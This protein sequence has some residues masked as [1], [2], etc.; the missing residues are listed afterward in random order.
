MIKANMRWGILIF[1]TIFSTLLTNYCRWI[2]RL[3]AF[4]LS[5]MPLPLCFI[6]LNIRCILCLF[7]ILGSCL[8]VGVLWINQENFSTYNKNKGSPCLNGQMFNNYW[9]AVYN[10]FRINEACC[11]TLTNGLMTIAWV[12]LLANCCKAC[13]YN[14]VGLLIFHF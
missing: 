9:L 11:H 13:I 5:A 7:R 2:R 3:V 12:N 14:V 8:I 1:I 6:W 4:W 10:T